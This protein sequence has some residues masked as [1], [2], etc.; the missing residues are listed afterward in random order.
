M[1]A[2]TNTTIF[3]ASWDNLYTIINSNTTD[4]D[5]KTKWIYTAFPD[6]KHDTKTAY[7]LII[8]NPIRANESEAVTLTRGTKVFPLRVV[9]EIYD[10]NTAQLDSV[11]D[12]VFDAVEAN[13]STLNTNKLHN[14]DLTFSDSET[15]FRGK[16]RVHR[17][18]LEWDFE[19]HKVG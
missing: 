19:Y 11:V 1:A 18:T 12:D 7:P 16:T 5:S 6:T 8:I 15:V 4:P 14:F 13:T 2:V 17:K 9:V 3:T 10:D